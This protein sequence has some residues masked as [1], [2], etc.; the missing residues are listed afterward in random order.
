MVI[1]RPTSIAVLLCFLWA[2]VRCLAAT[3]EQLIGTWSAQRDSMTLKLV[4]RAN[5][6]LQWFDLSADDPDRSPVTATWRADEQH[7]VVR[8]EL[9]DDWVK[10]PIFSI[11]RDTLVLDYPGRTTYRR[12]KP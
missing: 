3:E 11:T 9:R 8:W 4:L 6:A 12:N 2:A 10:I 5:H 7:L 1:V